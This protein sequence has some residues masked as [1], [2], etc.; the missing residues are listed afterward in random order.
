[1]RKRLLIGIFILQ[2]TAAFS[3]GTIRYVPSQY[4]TIQ[5]A[6]NACVDGDEVVI[7]TG[8][9]RGAGN[10]DLNFGGRAITVR[11]ADPNDPNIVAATIVDPNGTQAEPHRGFKFHSGEGSGSVVWG[12]TITNGYGPEEEILPILI[13][14]AG[15]AIFCDGSAPKIKS[16]IITDN[17]AGWGGGICCT[18]YSSPTISNC[19]ISGNTADRGGA[20]DCHFSSNPTISN[21]KITGN[22]TGWR[23]GGI[24]LANDSN[25]TIINCTISDNQTNEMGGGICCTQYSRPTIRNCTISGNSAHSGGGIM[26]GANGSNATISNCILWGDTGVVGA[27]IALRGTST[28]TISY[29]DVEGGRAGVGL[30]GS[31]NTLNW[32]IGNMDVNPNFVDPDNPNPS[33]RDYHLLPSSPCINAGDPGGDYSRQTDIDGEP[34][35]FSCT[36]DIGSDE[37]AEE[38]PDCNGNGIPDNCDIANGTSRDCNLN[39]V[40]DE[41]DIA[42]GTSKDCN[43]NGIPDECDIARGTSKDCNGNGIPDECDIAEGTSQ[44]LN[45]NGIPDECEPNWICYVDD[46]GPG[47]PA[48]GDPGTSDPNENGSIEHPFDSI[49]EAIDATVRGDTIII[50][51]DGTYTSEGNRDIDFKGKA[52]TLRSQNGP[53]NCI[54]DCEGTESENHRGFYFYNNEDANS[55]VEG[56][57]ITNAYVSGSYLEGCGGGICC[58]GTSPTISN[59]MVSQ[60]TASFAGAGIYCEDNSSPTITNCTLSSNTGRYGGGIACRFGSN[61]TI[62]NCTVSGNTTSLHGSGI[63]CW[64]SSPTVWNCTISGN[65]ANSGGGIHCDDGNPT[66]NNCILWD[67]TAVVGEEISVRG[68]STLTISYSD[69]Q[70]GRA[71]VYVRSDS[72]LNWGIGNMDVD[73][74]F[75]DPDNPNLSERDYHLLPGSPCINAGDPNGDYTGQTDIDGDPRVIAS[76]V[77]IGSDEVLAERDDDVDAGETVILNPGA[78]GADPNTKALVV[79]ENVSGPNHAV[80]EVTEVRTNLHPDGLFRALGRTLR[81]DTSLADGEFFMTVSIPFDVN[82]LTRE[83][84]FGVDLMYWDEVPGKWQHAVKANTDLHQSNPK[85]NRWQEEYPPTSAPTLEDLKARGIGANGV[86]WNSQTQQGFV[87]ANVDHTTDFEGLAHNVADFEP[88]GDVDWADFAWFAPN[89]MDTG[90]GVCGGAD[91]TGDGNVKL[92]DLREFAGNWLAGIE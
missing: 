36:V 4:D 25:P 39:R 37:V 78:G 11:S 28:V 55:A 50:V 30:L 33:E 31:G 42:N 83:E 12:V 67:N 58:Y 43:G 44:D 10:H 64:D 73:P 34:R 92:D 75:V 68:V 8:R 72:T 1:M 91:L 40:P 76:R 7:A 85:K 29:S 38:G 57:T 49:Q 21:C 87:W 79:F 32:G 60:N 26:S 89:W 88:D 90:C 52:I 35:V 77:D 17:F 54:I 46:D 48:P 45:Y 15:G 20:I 19:K 6:I 24:F 3:E 9:Y 82:D 23:G 47:D 2:A 14:S 53:A 69:V 66:V 70:G 59:C 27:E 84:P 56:F 65:T 41:C 86:F 51:L 62:R 61:A 13:V 74:N 71:K 18:W 80:I 63:Y 5:D 16:C 81:I 22:T